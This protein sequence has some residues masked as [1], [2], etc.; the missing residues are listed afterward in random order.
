M[1]V[2]IGVLLALMVFV[3][4]RW[5]WL[6]SQR[7]EILERHSLDDHRFD[8]GYGGDEDDRLYCGRVIERLRSHLIE[9]RVE[10]HWEYRR[11]FIHRGFILEAKCRRND[12][13]WQS[14]AM[15][16][17]QDSG[18]WI[19]CFNF[20][21][22]R[23]YVFTVRKDYYFFFGLLGETPV[24]VIYDQISF[25]VRKGKFLKEMKELARDKKEL[26]TEMAECSRA[27]QDFR[28]ELGHRSS[29]RALPSTNAQL[30]RLD[31]RRMEE[32]AMADYIEA[33]SE[34]INARR[35]W[36]SERKA[37]EIQRLNELASES[38]LEE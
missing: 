20:G 14:L 1:N 33:E 18:S 9:G 38:A 7:R 27:E 5:K 30:G 2:V 34:K 23:S 24:Q 8:A 25:S 26:Y 3:I 6:R 11:R 22:S 15:E 36:S 37:R 31:K 17:Y 10:I 13:E 29:S 4:W 21:E 12:G 35:D 16:P 28:R 19:E 32:V